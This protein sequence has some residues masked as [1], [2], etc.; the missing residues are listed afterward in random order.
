MKIQNFFEKVSNYIKKIIFDER[1][2]VQAKTDLSRDIVVKEK[3][4]SSL[5]ARLLPFDVVEKRRTE[6]REDLQRTLNLGY[7]FN[8][9]NRNYNGGKFSSTGYF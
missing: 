7:N 6:V 3:G 5:L 4:L 9:L 8:G 1:Y 2:V